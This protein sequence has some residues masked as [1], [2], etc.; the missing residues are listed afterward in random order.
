MV[1][2]A[3]KTL[4]RLD[5]ADLVL[6]PR[7]MRSIFQGFTV[8]VLATTIGVVPG[9][10]FSADGGAKVSLSSALPVEKNESVKPKIE[11]APIEVAPELPV[12]AIKHLSKST[13][14]TRATGVISRPRPVRLSE[15]GLSVQRNSHHRDVAAREHPSAIQNSSL[16]KFIALVPAGRSGANSAASLPVEGKKLAGASFAIAKPAKTDARSA[17]AVADSWEP[18]WSGEYQKHVG[19][20]STGTAGGTEQSGESPFETAASTGVSASYRL[21]NVPDVKSKSASIRPVTLQKSASP[22]SPAGNTV[23]FEAAGR[24]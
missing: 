20:A 19:P 3:M 23:T 7:S 22:E 17:P 12:P 14:I 6:N 4:V 13:V 11:A 21:P 24:Y 15:P 2:S 10:V 18:Q 8:A 1:P 16:P 5:R 9:L